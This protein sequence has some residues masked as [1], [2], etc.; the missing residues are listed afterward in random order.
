MAMGAK[1]KATA[2]TAVDL[3]S[4]TDPA[5]SCEVTFEKS[6]RVRNAVIYIYRNVTVPS[7][8]V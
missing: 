8:S 5:H 2:A 7:W 1:T 4:A 6:A 3:L